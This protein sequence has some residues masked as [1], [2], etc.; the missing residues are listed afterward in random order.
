MARTHDRRRAGTK[1]T[2]MAPAPGLDKTPDER[3]AEARADWL[4]A[5]VTGTEEGLAHAAHRLQR[6]QAWEDAVA[7]YEH[8]GE[9]FPHARAQAQTGAGDCWL[10]SVYAR[11]GVPRRRRV[12][13]LEKALDCYDRA[14]RAGDASRRLDESYWSACE[15]LAEALAGRRDEQLRVLRRYAEAFPEGLHRREATRW[16]DDLRSR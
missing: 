15:L 16:R 5:L 8:I 11:S 1:D 3:L 10:F 2:A 7:A 14:L 6:A 13:A 4:D 12:T 9:R